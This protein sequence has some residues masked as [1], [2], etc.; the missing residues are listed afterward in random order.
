VLEPRRS[1]GRD[2]LCENLRQLLHAPEHAV[3]PHSSPDTWS[4][5]LNLLAG[6][7]IS[8][9]NRQAE[10]GAEGS[11]R[12]SPLVAIVK[13]PKRSG[14]STFAREAVNRLLN[15]YETVAYLDCD[16]GQSEFGPGGTVGLYLVR[17]PLFGKLT[18]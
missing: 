7:G 18:C 10:E 17:K 14:K 16:L 11:D 8:D 5:A 3:Y 12:S 13:G 4:L 9:V 2:S 15:R 6:S 1:D